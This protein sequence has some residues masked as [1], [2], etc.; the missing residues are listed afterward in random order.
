[1]RIITSKSVLGLPETQLAIIPGAGGTQRTPRLIGNALAKEL[2][3]TG[4]RIDAA[5]ALRIGLTNYVENDAELAMTKAEE[6]AKLITNA[7]PIAIRAAKAAI[8]RGSEVDIESGLKIEE[9]LYY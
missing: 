6:L 2:I 8:N 3:L 7:G 1:M 4:R 9:M 5:E